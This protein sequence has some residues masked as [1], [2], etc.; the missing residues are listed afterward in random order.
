MESILHQLRAMVE[1]L[2]A[3]EEKRHMDIFIR[4]K[5][6]DVFNIARVDDVYILSGIDKDGNPS[7]MFC[8]HFVPVITLQPKANEHRRI[9]GFN[10]ACEIE[11]AKKSSESK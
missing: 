9:C 8:T 11:E 4:V 2:G 5:G 10:T 7:I 1:A 3:D 6:I